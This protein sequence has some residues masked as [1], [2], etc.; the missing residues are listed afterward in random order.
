MQIGRVGVAMRGLRS[1][2][3]RPLREGPWPRA[4]RKTQASS[5]NLHGQQRVIGLLVMKLTYF[6][7]DVA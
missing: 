7:S 4:L 2:E 6:D 1:A 5:P 3:L